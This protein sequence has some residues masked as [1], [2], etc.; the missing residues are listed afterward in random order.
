MPTGIP[1]V[2]VADLDGTILRLDSIIRD[3]LS[4]RLRH[5]TLGV[6]LAAVL[7]RA[8]SREVT[9]LQ[10]IAAKA[11]TDDVYARFKQT[12]EEARIQSEKARIAFDKHVAEHGC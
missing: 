9:S 10:K 4:S 7:T 5:S 11:M 1:G 12:M 3:G 8:Y 6:R 2:Q